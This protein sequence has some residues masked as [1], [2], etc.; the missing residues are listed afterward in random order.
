MSV[1]AVVSFKVKPNKLQPFMKLLE[2]NQSNM[3]SAGAQTVSLL[4]DTDTRNRVV[5]IEKWD[6]IEDH[7]NFANLAAQ[8]PAFKQLKEYLVEPYKVL[9]LEE[10]ARL[11]AF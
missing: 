1:T 2:S 6:S 7:Q 9:Y 5:E 10:H 3:I 8:S 4:Q 11:D